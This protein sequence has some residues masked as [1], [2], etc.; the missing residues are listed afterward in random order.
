MP[1]GWGVKAGMVRVLV[2]GKTVWSPRYTRAISERFRDKELIINSPSLLCWLFLCYFS[3]VI[4]ALSYNGGSLGTD[5]H[6]LRDRDALKKIYWRSFKPQSHCPDLSS[7]S[8]TKNVAI[9]DLSEAIYRKRCKIGGKLLLITN[10]KS[11]MG[12][13]LVQNSVTLKYLERRNRPNSCVISP[14]SVAFWADCVYVVEYIRI[15][16]AAE[17]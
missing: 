4:S 2:A 17:M 7:R 5:E 1:C 12:F 3:E 8:S 11:Y 9:L 15:L 6:P 10:G 13:R 16:S 14:N